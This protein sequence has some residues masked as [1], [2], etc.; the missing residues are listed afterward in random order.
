[1]SSDEKSGSQRAIKRPRVPPGPLAD[2]KALLYQLYLEAGTPTLDE[3]AAWIAADEDLAGAPGRASV[4]RI[5]GSATMP[6]SQ[7]DLVTVVTVLARAAWWDPGDAAQ[8][9]RD[10]WV[11]ARMDSA[12]IPAGG[13]RVSE[14]EPRRLGVHAAISVPGVADEV[15]PEYVP[16]DA[17]D[18][19]LG[20]RAKVAAAAKRGGF[21]LLVGGSS[22]GKTRC[23]F[24][25]ARALLPDWWLAHP[26]GPAEV[27]ALA[28]APTARTVVWL[29]ELQRHL[30]GEHGLTG[31]VVR[32]LLNPP[33]PAVIIGTLWPDRY[34]AYTTPPIPGGADPHERKR[35]VLQLADVV[36]IGPEFSPAEQGRAQAAAAKDPR[37]A[38]ALEATGYGLTQT[39]A[40]APQL[41][42]RWQDARAGSPYGWAVLT[43]AL[44]VARLGTR[45][46]LS[47]DLL[48]AAA[49]GYCTSAQQAEA[50]E[51]WFEQAMSYTTEK[52]HGAAAAL[53][54][55]GAGMGQVAGYSVADYL[56]HHA[57]RARRSAQVPASTW[58]AATEH[59]RDPA[60]IS[61]LA[62]S[63]KNRLL[64]RYALKL[65]T[66][67]GDIHALKAAGELLQEAGRAE[68]AL[69]FYW[70]AAEAGDI[71]APGAA[72]GILR[73]A[74]RIEEAFAVYRRAAEADGERNTD[75][76]WEAAQML[77][78][79]GRIEEALAW[80]ESRAEAGDVWALWAAAEALGAAGRIEE[81]LAFYQR[82]AE[83][84]PEGDTGP[85]WAA[86][87]ML[88]G[89]GRIEE[90]DAALRRAVEAPGTYAHVPG[91]M[92]PLKVEAS[93][94]FNRQAAED[95]DT[96][97]LGAA[98]HMMMSAGR[99]EEALAWL[100]SRAEAG[101]TGAPGAAAETLR[102]AGRIEEAL[103]FYQRAAEVGD[104]GA[105]GAAA[106]MLREAGRIEE[107]LAFYRRA[108]E[109]GDTR[110]LFTAADAL[111]EGGRIDEALAVYRRAA[112]AGDI[113]ALFAATGMLREARGIEEALAWLES[114]AEAGDTGALFAA[115][116]M[117]RAMRRIEEALA[118]YLRA[119]EAGDTAAPG[120]AAGMLREAGRPEEAERLRRYGI[121]PGGRIADPWET[122]VHGEDPV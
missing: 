52:L 35:E 112:E 46:L 42:D 88:Q 2:L 96:R 119:A 3:I 38:V 104:T 78:E 41:V 40:A 120:A 87:Q 91:V 93:I 113:Y 82:A 59:V 54:P 92:T 23:A 19:E 118:F 84:A 16:R 121:E 60:D 101:D 31:G 106:E 28:K 79:A 8:R 107:A 14:A 25:A 27:S 95:G 85:L 115:A 80:L 66:E 74:G 71:Y 15:L 45:G 114:R 63:T 48:R 110:A 21:V 108:A 5:I 76:L 32:A 12:R 99:I 13:V 83:A 65:Y 17:D 24:E 70:R 94:T 68:E 53:T 55:A 47:A 111:Q 34:T 64:Y 10:L 98:A 109:G 117:L 29:D 51:N 73:E 69:A 89:A 50:P 72:A 75:V 102:K 37:L 90:A 58:D 67:A 18:G 116:G 103:T 61:R 1:M 4:A 122:S 26:A 7:A 22:V 86:A 20:V 36:R 49:P 77:Q 39:L 57:S 9:A 44:D 11:E 56:L 6:P 97:A 100:E 105:P 43:A 30:D 33:H 81:A 62:D